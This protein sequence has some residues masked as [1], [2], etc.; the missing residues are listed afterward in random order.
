[1]S[2]QKFDPI[3][4]FRRRS[5]ALLPLLLAISICRADSVGPPSSYEVI[6]G[7]NDEYRFVML[8]DQ[9][10]VT[11]DGTAYPV[12]GLYRNDGST[13]PLWQVEW[14]APSV[15]IKQD[16]RH[17]V[18]LGP[19]ASVLEDLAVE[20]Y[21]RDQLLKSYRIAQLIKDPD[22]LSH[23]VSHFEWYTEMAFDDRRGI[24]RIKT[25][26]G[27]LLFFSLENGEIIDQPKS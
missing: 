10:I 5:L 11:D 27:Q 26:D 19:W 16:G 6:A 23:S 14:H 13:T 12:S 18:R 2:E 25:L 8:A 21:D 7:A 24:L 9:P 1:M 4:S 15:R 17:L 3:R 20:F 22:K